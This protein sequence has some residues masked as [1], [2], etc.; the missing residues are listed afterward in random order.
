MA[1]P[2]LHIKDSYYFEVPKVLCPSNFQSL[3]DFPEVWTRLDPEFQQWEFDR[4]YEELA[5]VRDIG[6]LLQPK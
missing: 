4:L 2:V 6:P 1:N 3:K 5:A